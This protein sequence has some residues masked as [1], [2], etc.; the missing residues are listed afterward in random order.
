[1]LPQVT[2]DSIVQRVRAILLTQDGK[3]MFIKRIKPNGA[4]Y[5]VAPG[6][7]VEGSESLMATLERELYEELGATYTVLREAFVLEHEKAG[8]RLEEHFYI[9]KLIDY[10]LDLRCGP[11]FNDPARGEFL[12]D[13]VEIGKGAIIDLNI[14]T[15]ELSNWLIQNTRLLRHLAR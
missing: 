6:G 14:K 13:E 10:D 12:P 8:K 2:Q 15:P 4:P 7:G 9:C 1:M 5:W 3:L 11:E